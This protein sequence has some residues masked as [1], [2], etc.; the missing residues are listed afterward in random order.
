MTTRKWSD[1]QILHLSKTNNKRMMG[2]ISKYEFTCVHNLSVPDAQCVLHYQTLGNRFM[3][4][5]KLQWNSCTKP[6]NSK[7][8]HILLLT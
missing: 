3:I 8:N 1:L 7:D 5:T 4:P 6:V 2:G